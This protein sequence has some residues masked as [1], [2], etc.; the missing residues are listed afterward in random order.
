[1]LTTLRN[2][3]K[4]ISEWRRRTRSRHELAMLGERGR[5]DL[6]WRFDVQSEM[7]KPFWQA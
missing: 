3:R 2:T 5:R 4:I 7:C 1:M 6:A